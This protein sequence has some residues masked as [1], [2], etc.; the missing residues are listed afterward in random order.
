MTKGGC[1]RVFFV[2]KGKENEVFEAKKRK[3]KATNPSKKINITV[4]FSK[5]RGTR[6]VFNSSRWDFHF[7]RTNFL[8]HQDETF[9]SSGRIDESFR[10]IK[11]KKK[12]SG[13]EIPEVLH[14]KNNQKSEVLASFFEGYVI[15]HRT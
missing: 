14:Q 3:K 8:P 6:V 10:E 13:T 9:V 12:T 11:H 5:K 2:K 15:Q 7:V 4:V 1:F